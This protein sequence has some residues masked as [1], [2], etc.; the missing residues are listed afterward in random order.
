MYS[1]MSSSNSVSFAVS[2]PIW[3]PFISISSVI[4]VAVQICDLQIC[5]G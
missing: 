5:V 3:I 4:A 2:F 1:M